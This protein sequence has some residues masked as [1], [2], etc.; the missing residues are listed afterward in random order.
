[1]AENLTLP[2]LFDGLES[3]PP[4]KAKPKR[5]PKP[6]P[7]PSAAAKPKAKDRR[8]A[9]NRERNEREAKARAPFYQ[10]DLAVYQQLAPGD[11]VRVAFVSTSWRAYDGEPG[12]EPKRVA[13]YEVVSKGTERPFGGNALVA[14]LKPAK[15]K[16]WGKLILRGPENPDAPATALLQHRPRGEGSALTTGA[17]VHLS[18]PQ[19]STVPQELLARI[20]ARGPELAR[21][22]ATME[23]RWKAATPAERALALRF[24]RGAEALEGDDWRTWESFVAYRK[25]IRGMDV[26]L[27]PISRDRKAKHEAHAKILPRIEIDFPDESRKI[28]VRYRVVSTDGAGAPKRGIKRGKL[29]KIEYARKLSD[30]HAAT[31]WPNMAVVDSFGALY[32]DPRPPAP[33]KPTGFVVICEGGADPDVGQHVCAKPRTLAEA[34]QAAVAHARAWGEAATIYERTRNVRGRL[35]E[36]VEKPHLGSMSEDE[37]EI[38]L[39]ELEGSLAKLE[40]RAKRSDN[41]SSRREWKTATKLKKVWLDKIRRARSARGKTWTTKPTGAILT[42]WEKR[43]KVLVAHKWPGSMNQGSY[44]IRKETLYGGGKSRDVYRVYWAPAGSRPPH[45]YLNELGNA[46]HRHFDDHAGVP[47]G[48]AP[49][50]WPT[51]DEAKVVAIRHAQDDLPVSEPRP[52]PEKPKIPK[53]WKPE[54]WYPQSEIEYFERHKHHFGKRPEEYADWV[55]KAFPWKVWDS[56]SP[57]FYADPSDPHFDPAWR[58]AVMGRAPDDPERLSRED[59]RAR[60]EGYGVVWERLK[61]VPVEKVKAA[62]L[63]ATEDGRPRTWNRIAVEAFG[64]TADVVTRNVE[65]GLAELVGEQ[66]LAFANLDGGILFWNDAIWRKAHAKPAKPGE[67]RASKSPKAKGKRK[68]KPKPKP[69]PIEWERKGYAEEQRVLEQAGW[70]TWLEIRDADMGPQFAGKTIL[71]TEP[72]PEDTIDAVEFREWLREYKDTPGRWNEGAYIAVRSS[73]V[74]GRWQLTW[75]RDGEPVGDSERDTLAEL[76]ELARADGAYVTQVVPR[77]KPK[78]RARKPR[79]PRKPKAPSVMDQILGKA[80][81]QPDVPQGKLPARFAGKKLTGSQLEALQLESW[82][83]ARYPNLVER[84]HYLV[85]VHDAL[86]VVNT[87]GGKDS[88]AMFLYLTRELKLPEANVFLIHADLPGADWPGTTAWIE[89]TSEPFKVNVVRAGITF[90]GLVRHR[91]EFPSAKIRNC[92]SDLKRGP[93]QK[94]IRA[95]LCMRANLKPGCSKLPRD[96]QRI[97]INA[98]GMRAQESP[99]RSKAETWKVDLKQTAANRLVFDWLPIHAWTHDQVFAY[100]K[101]HGQS[102]FWIYGKTPA[103]CKRLIE[104]GSVNEDGSC[105]PMTRMSC[106]FCILADAGDQITACML[107]P[108]RAEQICCLEKETGRTMKATTRKRKGQPDELIRQPLEDVIEKARQ[109]QQK[110]IRSRKLKVLP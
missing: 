28:P 66:K 103:D 102:P 65:R 32:W 83:E 70:K 94:A 1:M 11:R 77:A 35:V 10:A 58:Y 9:A 98:M 63:K 84:V 24:A 108:K 110:G 59:A 16:R 48:V 38:L 92:T 49:D 43:G 20:A 19:T 25:M 69:K 8:T 107:S 81:V 4:A 37:L 18:R 15:G 29:S 109:I 79:K 57:A 30:A 23:K 14:E 5:E 33:R 2:G 42:D 46:V 95:T 86:V 54:G 39:T 31:G 105:R 87:S 91:K 106:Q 7:K 21:G 75:F 62:I 44:E 89:K 36:R 45:N 12:R 68:P 3:E 34:Q 72:P 50:A 64:I 13:E 76:V 80:P 41:A 96:A 101:K 74:P 56:G 61:T 99:R 100:I 22:I 88:Q 6:K 93:I 55:V 82:L 71:R 67:T 73:K 78:Q 85:R 90:D 40:G 17:W 60:G 97:V 104:Q 52:V 26:G 53:S 51:V 27:G 47:R